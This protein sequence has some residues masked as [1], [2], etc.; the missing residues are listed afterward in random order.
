M[1]R[2]VTHPTV[3]V[4]TPTTPANAPVAP[5]APDVTPVPDR[6]DPRS[7]AN[8]VVDPI[9]TVFAP[10]DGPQKM[11]LAHLDAIIAAKKAD[12]KTYPVGKNPYVIEYAV[13][14]MTDKR[15][16][17]RLTEA[18]RAGIHVQLLIDADQISPDKPHNTVVADLVAAGFS[19]AQSQ[20]GLTPEQQ[21]DTQIIEIDM[22][23]GL[24]H[25]KSRYFSYPDP[26]TGVQ[27]ETLLTGSHNPQ[28]SA[29]QNDESLHRISDPAL[30]KKYL[31]A[32]E[33]L[34]SDK[35]IQN[36]WDDASPVNVLF[37]SPTSTGPKVVDKIFELVR[38]EKELIFLSV[39]TL[40][41]ITDSGRATLVDEL[42]KARE[43]GVKVVVVTDRKQ[44]DGI[45]AEGNRRSDSN[46]DNTDELLQSAGIP[47]YEV[48]NRAGPFTAMHLKSAVFGLSDIKVVTDAGNWTF[49]TM[50]SGSKRSKNA[51]SVL[52]IDSGKYDG[53][54]TGQR[55]L[56]EFMRV[57][58]KYDDQNTT[59]V[60]T[61]KTL[62]DLQASPAWPRVKVNFD[63]LAR[64]QVGQDVYIT[65]DTPELGGWGD[66]GPGLKLDT[67]PD[68]YPYWKKAEVELPLGMRLEY[69]VVKRDSD[70][71]LDWEPGQNAVLVVDP[72]QSKDP[73]RLAV[74]EDFNGDG[75]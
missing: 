41:N 65:G 25:L 2:R 13:Y 51:E 6:F 35:P 16:V 48:I 44:S 53:N 34:R 20:H 60:A 26:V 74:S 73:A 15:L 23:A 72:T 43:R 58:R 24:F 37:T 67:N 27:K 32:I 17:Q 31:G 9:E 19:H 12:P 40:R 68:T 57:M 46:N 7:P 52:F 29:N 22:G 28:N 63:V 36:T 59:Q 18:A 70:G 21:R 64:T 33:A 3:P 45:D 71:R 69:K 75:G 54:Q 47:T 5:V 1:P 50:G 10:S 30:I 8:N 62:R 42:V 39:F 55:Y 66:G 11:E 61:E 4:T 49:A 14:N 38:A 56:G